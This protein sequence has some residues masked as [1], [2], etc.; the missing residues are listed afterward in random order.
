MVME[1]NTTFNNIS[2]IS[3]Q[4]VLMKGRQDYRQAASGFWTLS[5]I[6]VIRLIH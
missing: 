1:F 6:V 3:W 5:Q 4:S 2:V